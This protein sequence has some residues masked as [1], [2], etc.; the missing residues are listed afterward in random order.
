MHI[1]QTFTIAAPPAD[2]FAFMADPEKLA[3]WQTVKTYVTPVS[4]GPPRLGYRVR[5]G[6]KVGPREWEQ[7]VE[8]TE[9]EPGRVLA[10]KVIEGPESDGRWTMEPDGAG[11]RIHFEAD[12]KA[13]PLVGPL[14]R[15]IVARNFRAYHEN[16]RRELEGGQA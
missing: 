8:L 11:T 6:T 2:V 7:L 5:E 15:R 1:E 9:F 4:E 14:L 12:M 3:R 16:L 13:P 10:V